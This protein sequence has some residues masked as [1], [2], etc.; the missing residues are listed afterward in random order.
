M[1]EEEV[2][3][4]MDEQMSVEEGVPEFYV[5]NTK[6]AVSP[7]DV[8]INFGLQ[9][10][11]AQSVEDVVVIRMSLQHALVVSRLLLKNL[12][13]AEETIGRINLPESLQER[14]GIEEGNPDGSDAE[15]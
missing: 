6:F 1:S 13:T 11:S 14:L 15:G 4:E 5:N 9:S 10:G 3:E 12:Q 8:Q 2:K 7:Y